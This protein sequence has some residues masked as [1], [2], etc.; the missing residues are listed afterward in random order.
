MAKRR[1]E[2]RA[3]A[4]AAGET[5]ARILQA[6]YARLRE[7][8]AQPLSVERVARDAG[9]A[10]STVYLVFGSR[11]GLFDA[12]GADLLRRDAYGR[13][14]DAVALPDAREGLRAAVTA[15]AE[16]FASDLHVTRA[17][18][19]MARL[20]ADAVGGAVARIEETRAQGT[21]RMARRLAAQGHLRPGLTDR[22]AAD[23]L[24]VLTSFEAFD[25]LVA[26]R[27]R[28]PADAAAEL[29]RVAEHALCA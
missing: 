19:A 17:L 1:Y 27:G 25:L 22:E 15:G 4:E 12:I 3:R 14:L 20:D 29:A 6:A 28:T 26:G 8:P 10:R 16:M 23:L 21:A 24:W 5:R 11:A 9:V 2:Q 13:L 7:A 18:F